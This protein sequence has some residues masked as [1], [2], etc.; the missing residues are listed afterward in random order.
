MTDFITKSS[1]SERWPGCPPIWKMLDFSTNG[2]F[3]PPSTTNPSTS[4]GN[5]DLEWMNRFFRQIFTFSF[6]FVDH[7][8]SCVSEFLWKHFL[9]HHIFAQLED[10]F[11]ETFICLYN[12]VVVSLPWT[13]ELANDFLKSFFI[14]T[15]LQRWYITI[16]SSDQWCAT[17]ENHRYQWLSYPKTIGKPLIPMVSPQPFHSMVMVTLKTIE[18]LRW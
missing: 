18:S 3:S 4:L 6:P 10:F 15:R 2:S 17:I 16:P 13:F 14:C 12:K 7:M 9:L 11:L 1:S 8:K 5:Q